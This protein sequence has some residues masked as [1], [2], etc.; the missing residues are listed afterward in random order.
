MFSTSRFVKEE[1]PALGLGERLGTVAAPANEAA[2]AVA[3]SATSEAQAKY[4]QRQPEKGEI[5]AA[6]GLKAGANADLAASV[7]RKPVVLD[8]N[9]E[10]AFPSLGA[11]NS[12]RQAQ[13]STWGPIKTVASSGAKKLHGSAMLAGRS[14]AEISREVIDLPLGHGGA[15]ST[16]AATDIAGEVARIM[17]RTGTKI[18][19]SRATQL[20]TITFLVTGPKAGIA[21]AKREIISNLSPKVT[22]TFQVPSSARPYIV[23]TKG[24]TLQGI[25]N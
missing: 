18:E 23:G 14:K 9:S 12:T 5:A 15:T 21:Q 1:D 10:K 13:T 19:M 2:V 3:P 17:Q 7:Q 11:A 24:K 20:Q 4:Y 16:N 22:A 25:Q 8:L 6:E